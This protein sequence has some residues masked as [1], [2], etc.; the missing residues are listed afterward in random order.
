MHYGAHQLVVPGNTPGKRFCLWVAVPCRQTVI[1]AGAQT[2][3]CITPPKYPERVIVANLRDYAVSV[4]PEGGY[5]GIVILLMK[6]L[7]QM[8]AAAM[9]RNNSANQRP[10]I[11]C[12]S[13]H[14]HL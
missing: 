10:A 5:P 11:S 8:S 13:A 6:M 9:L 4:Y 1:H 14:G 2:E 3:A 7:Q 12:A